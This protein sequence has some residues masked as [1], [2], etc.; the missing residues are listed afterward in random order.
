MP[1]TS[2][3]YPPFIYCGIYSLW[4]LYLSTHPQNRTLSLHKNLSILPTI[5]SDL[6]LGVNHILFTL[7]ARF[8]LPVYASEVKG[9]LS[10][11]HLLSQYFG[12]NLQ[13]TLTNLSEKM[14]LAY[15]TVMKYVNEVFLARN[16]FPDAAQCN[17]KQERSEISKF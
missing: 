4:Y 12:G 6:N 7:P 8:F 2:K 5:I 17:H 15:E 11:C 10:Q 1:R 13:I 16:F 3:N 14:N 9:T